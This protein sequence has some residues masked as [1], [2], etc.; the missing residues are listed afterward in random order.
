M[1]LR[2]G[3]G[4]FTPQ[5]EDFGVT[6]RTCPLR[7][8]GNEEPKASAIWKPFFFDLRRGPSRVIFIFSP[9]T[10]AYERTTRIL[11]CKD[12]MALYAFV[13]ARVPNDKVIV[14][15]GYI[16]WLGASFPKSQDT[17]KV[18]GSENFVQKVPDSVQVLIRNL[19]KH[20]TR[21]TQ[22]IPRQ[23]QPVAQ[24]R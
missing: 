1:F 6:R 17:K 18:L 15:S 22:Q 7:S 16:A 14:C 23:Q 20:A 13:I 24:I 11:R 19:H 8:L 9:K 12:W 21:F 5:R 4:S 3:L 2:T 10:L